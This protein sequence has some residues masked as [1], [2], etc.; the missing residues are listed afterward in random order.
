MATIKQNETRVLNVMMM[1][2]FWEAL[3]IT[4]L[5]KRRVLFLCVCWVASY[6]FSIFG[7]LLFCDKDAFIVFQRIMMKIGDED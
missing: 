5:W 2:V 4:S 7:D 1:L 3:E 6:V